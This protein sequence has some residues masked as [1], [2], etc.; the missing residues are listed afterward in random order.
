V[1]FGLWQG[2]AFPGYRLANEP[3]TLVR[4]DLVTPRAK[5]ARDFYASVFGF[6]LDGNPTLPDL[7]FTFLRRQDGYEIGGIM[8]LA[9]AKSL[10]APTFE[11][12]DTDATLA[13]AG[14]TVPPEDTPYGRSATLT[15]PFGVEFSV[16][17]RP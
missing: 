3:N 11:V 10:W 9:D 12:G 5:P 2:R 17:A 4:N 16:I 15:D 14:S 7:D 1:T 6:T 8:G 13:R